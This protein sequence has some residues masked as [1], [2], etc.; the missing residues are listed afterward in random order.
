LILILLATAIDSQAQK[1]YGYGYKQSEV[2]TSAATISITPKNSLT[3]FTLV[4]THS[5]TITPTTTYAVIGD[6]L[7]FSI[8]SSGAARTITWGTGFTGLADVLVSGK[9]HMIQFIWDG[10]TYKKLSTIQID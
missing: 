4:A 7:V 2:L 3:L 8:N 6:I 5:P 9:N 1:K 10:T